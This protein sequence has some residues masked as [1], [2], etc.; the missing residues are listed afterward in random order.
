MTPPRKKLKAKG[1]RLNWTPLREV[2][3]MD[4]S[5]LQIKGS[6]VQVKNSGI[7]NTTLLVP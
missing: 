1:D 7:V 6:I 2:K 3:P 4:L 5:L